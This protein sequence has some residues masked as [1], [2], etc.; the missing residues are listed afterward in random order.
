ML[1]VVDRV[2]VNPMFVCGH[3]DK[4]HFFLIL[5]LTVNE[6]KK[7]IVAVFIGTCHVTSALIQGAT[8]SCASVAKGVAL[9]VSMVVSIP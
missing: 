2:M 8:I 4:I 9:F 3:V 7:K 5:A 6:S 1:T